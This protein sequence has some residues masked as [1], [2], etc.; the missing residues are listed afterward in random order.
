MLFNSF[1]FLLFF[2]IVTI[3]FFVIPRKVRYLWL[4]VA[5]YYFYM[6]WNVKY[7][8]LLLFSTLITWGLGLILP[9]ISSKSS[10][11]LV[12]LTGLFTN[13]AV[14]FFF[15]YF[16]FFY[17]NLGRVLGKVG[18]TLADS[19]FDF[20]LPVGI[21]FYIFQALGYLID[22]YREEIQPEK[23]VLRYALFVSFFPQLVA[24]PIE[25]SGRLLTQIQRMEEIVVFEGKRIEEG[26]VLMF[27]GLFQ[28][29]VIADRIAIFVDNIFGNLQG[30][31]TIETVLAA[32]G[33]SLQIYCDFAGYSNIAIG[34]A[35]VMGFELME[36]F[37]TPYF[38]TNIA[39]FW[40]RWH[41]SLSTWF[42]DYLYIPLGGNRKGRLRKYLNLMITFLV[43]GLWHGSNWTYILWGGIHGLYQIVG[44]C[45]RPWKEK[46][47]KACK[48]KTEAES[49]RLGQILVTFLLTS[50][51]WIFFRSTS[52]SK[53]VLYVKRMLTHFN[54]WV[55]FDQSLFNW[56][57]DRIEVDVLMPA[58]ILL[59]L[60]EWIRYRKKETIGQF[61]VRQNTW[62]YW[63]GLL[64]LILSILVFG[65]Y[66]V[67]F[68]SKQFV[69]FAF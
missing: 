53:A 55:L 58:L 46:V 57:L 68:D 14:L 18:I 4:L 34:A 43:S 65:E 11:K 66:G 2:P 54:P 36:N 51:A 5:S 35:K 42:R 21:S 19:P 44:D 12:M 26:L 29:M 56:G 48:V 33:F 8:V 10:R 28:K 20:L 1:E 61:L 49:F 3:L 6:C 64:L 31:G 37:N 52:L 41:I 45:I 60:V 30:I 38:A 62:F 47:Y 25:R 69:Y 50:F 27:W 24:G 13:L 32:I 63:G 59:F 67:L 40:R 15:K 17:S 39:D 7:V 9:K 16:N 22:V 23:N